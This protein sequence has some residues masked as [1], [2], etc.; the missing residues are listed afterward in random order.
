M[1]KYL[2]PSLMNI[3]ELKSYCALS[4][5][6]QPPYTNT[7]I[8][9]IITVLDDLNISYKYEFKT[10]VFDE[11]KTPLLQMRQDCALRFP[12]SHFYALLDDDMAF[13]PGI[14]TQYLNLLAAM[15]ENSNIGV[16]RLFRDTIIT[17]NSF[18][19]DD[20]DTLDL[21]FSTGSGII[22][23]GG[24]YYDF[25]GLMPENLCEL[26]GGKQDFACGIYRIFQGNLAV[27]MYNAKC[28]HYENRAL[29]GYI[30]YDWSK[31]KTNDTLIY[32]LE[33][34][35]C[36]FTTYEN[37]FIFVKNRSFLSDIKRK[38]LF[39]KFPYF[40]RYG[41]FRALP[42]KSLAQLQ[43]ILKEFEIVRY[44]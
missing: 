42:I 22:Y 20:T 25:I 30:E 38:E 6:F 21:M 11:G 27:C 36:L 15:L 26:V 8:N 2:L 34:Q 7:E 31:F 43:N 28:A 39:R 16:A 41:Q 4:I 17:A 14:D 10:Y 3:G 18:R 19:Y 35:G 24:R 13:E 1:K 33:Q 44:N 12:D 32:W 9:E 5:T 40:K 37:R 29:P 23:R